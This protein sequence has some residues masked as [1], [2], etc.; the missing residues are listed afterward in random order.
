MRARTW[1]SC[2]FFGSPPKCVA[3]V[4]HARNARRPLGAPKCSLLVSSSR[5]GRHVVNPTFLCL[6]SLSKII[7][8]STAPL[9]VAGA[10]SWTPDGV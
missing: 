3:H 1:S 10:Y 2:Q 5:V 8:L 4:W 7:H 9:S 6:A